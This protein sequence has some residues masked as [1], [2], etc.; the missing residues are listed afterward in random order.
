M[1]VPRARTIELLRAYL[2]PQHKQQVLELLGSKPHIISAPQGTSTGWSSGDGSLL[3]QQPG[4]SMEAYEAG[5]CQLAGMKMGREMHL[6]N[7]MPQ[8]EQQ[9]IAL[10]ALSGCWKEHVSEETLLEMLFRIYEGFSFPKRMLEWLKALP[11]GE[12]SRER[13]P[14]IPRNWWNGV[15]ERPMPPRSENQRTRTKRSDLLIRQANLLQALAYIE[16]T[17]ALHGG[18]K[19]C[20]PSMSQLE[21]RWL[22]PSDW[23]KPPLE[24]LPSGAP[25]Q[26]IQEQAA[27][28]EV[29]SLS[30]PEDPAGWRTKACW[31]PGRRARHLEVK[32]IIW[33]C[34]EHREGGSRSML[35]DLP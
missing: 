12:Q 28:S 27:A 30:L 2:E 19:R 33:I 21:D 32:T 17:S 25:W 34:M 7:R 29:G 23:H 9:R 3:L 18:R 8:E 22:P 1:D 10:M 16:T 15:N 14:S 31:A 26:E 35:F 24:R 13:W 20:L 5:L 4:L 6:A 11:L